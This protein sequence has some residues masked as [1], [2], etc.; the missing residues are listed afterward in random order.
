VKL[1]DPAQFARYY[2][3]EVLDK[4]DPQ[5]VLQDLGGDNFIMCCWEA[6]GEFCH[7]QVVAVWLKLAGVD[8]EELNPKLRRHDAWLRQM[9]GV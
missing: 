5:K 6:A 2:R 1:T 8:V 4:L 3:L 9:R 7:R